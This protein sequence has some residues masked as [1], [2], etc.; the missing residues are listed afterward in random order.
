MRYYQKNKSEGFRVGSAL[1]KPFLDY[2]PFGEVMPGRSANNTA[3]RYTF[4]GQERDAELNWNGFELRTFDGRLGRWNN[5]DP[6]RQ[7]WSPFVAMGNNPISRIDPDGGRDYYIDGLPVSERMMNAFMN[8]NDGNINVSHGGLEA[9]TVL[10]YEYDGKQ[11]YGDQA[12][13]RAGQAKIEDV[14]EYLTSYGLS[15]LDGA[16]ISYSITNTAYANQDHSITGGAVTM[17]YHGEFSDV[18]YLFGYGSNGLS[19]P[20]LFS[21]DGIYEQNS[22]GWNRLVFDGSHLSVINPDGSV[23]YSTP[24]T[25]GT[26]IHMNNPGSQGIQDKGP[27]P[28]GDYYFSNRHWK[29]QSKSRQWYNIIR[30]NG[31]WGDYNVPLRP[32]TYNGPRNSFYL[33]GGYFEGSAGC[34][35]VG[36]NIENIYNYFKDQ[37]HTILRVEY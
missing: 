15:L 1:H 19:S 28:E 7:H 24:A 33:H 31:D 17:N 32:L 9:G 34:I 20:D 2:Y 13:E 25:S 16:L 8:G 21:Y 35:D 5:H 29:S 18:A 6:Y 12:H 10:G 3:Y 11:Y 36:C 14:R 27:I 23:L 37:K 26:G 4:Q 30:G 22:A